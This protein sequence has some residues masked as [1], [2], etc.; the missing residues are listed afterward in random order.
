[1]NIQVIFLD[2]DL[3]AVNK[4]AG[5]TTVKGGLPEGTP[6]LNLGLESDYGRLYPV[7]RLDRETSGI[8]LFGRTA[9]A[10]REL[11]QQFQERKVTKTYHLLTLGSCAQEN[12]QVDLPLRVNVG[13]HRRTNVDYQKGK[14]A[15][16]QFSI[17]KRF[18]E[19]ICLLSAQPYSGYT[20]QIRVHASAAGLWILND[21]LYAPRTLSAD[22][23]NATFEIP[24]NGQRIT[25]Q[26]PISRLALHAWQIEFSH[27]GNREKL[28]LNA[29]YP[30]DFQLS[31]DWLDKS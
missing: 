14:P 6:V 12:F 15:R 16:T 26:L 3:L 30:Q 23:R 25:S 17:I 13:H 4:P 1:M 19:G 24:V 29:P 31:L 10:H 9:Q 11:N 2:D 27:P 5:I 8:I 7:H 28:T 20:H 22:S 18:R 21:S